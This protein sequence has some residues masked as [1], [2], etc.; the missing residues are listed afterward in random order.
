[1]SFSISNNV[2][3]FIGTFRQALH[4]KLGIYF[5]QQFLTLYKTIMCFYENFV[6]KGEKCW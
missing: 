2:Q 3:F 4:S 1:M 6:E 5:H